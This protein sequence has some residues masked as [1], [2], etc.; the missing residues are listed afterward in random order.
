V[1]VDIQQSCSQIVTMRLNH[2][3]LPSL[4][5]A[6]PLNSRCASPQDLANEDNTYDYIV[7]GSGPGGGKHFLHTP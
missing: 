5:L 6:S 3:L 4:A 2:L 1:D 7:T